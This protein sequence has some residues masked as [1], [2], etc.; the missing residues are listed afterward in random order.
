MKSFCFS[1]KVEKE[2]DYFKLFIRTFFISE[3]LYLFFFLIIIFFPFFGFV[4]L[5][6]S[7]KSIFNSSSYYFYF[8]FKYS[9][10]L[11]FITDSFFTSF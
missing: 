2:F 3:I 7:F 4:Y 5:V 8:S 10:K 11:E 1:L 9:H 6:F